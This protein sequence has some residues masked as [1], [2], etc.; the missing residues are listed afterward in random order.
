MRRCG[1]YIRTGFKTG[2][3]LRRGGVVGP[4]IRTRVRC[5]IGVRKSGRNIGKVYTK[6][7]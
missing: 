5:G 3:G 7:R 6:Y 1:S 4:S 2:T